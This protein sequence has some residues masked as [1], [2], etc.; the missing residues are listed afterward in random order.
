MNRVLIPVLLVF[1]I[2]CNPGNID[3]EV[4]GFG[5]VKGKFICDVDFS[6]VPF[7]LYFDGMSVLSAQKDLI[8]YIEQ[9]GWFVHNKGM[10]WMFIPGQITEKGVF[11][12]C[13]L[14][15]NFLGNTGELESTFTLRFP[16]G[17]KLGDIT[18]FIK[19]AKDLW[20]KIKVQI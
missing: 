14:E 5:G 7:T 1:L 18:R 11:G 8:G 17:I 19:I 3:L 12:E 10:L 15:Y 13:I 6:P 16:P 9:D 20:P 2:S 4:D